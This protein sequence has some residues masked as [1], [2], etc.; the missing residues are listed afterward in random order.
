MQNLRLSL[1]QPPSLP[2]EVFRRI[3]VIPAH[4]ARAARDA[5]DLP[6]STAR[7]AREK[8]HTED[9]YSPQS[10]EIP[11]SRARCSGLL[12]TAPGGHT[13]YPPL[14]MLNASPLTRLSLVLASP[15]SV[16]ESRSAGT[17]QLGPPAPVCER[18]AGHRSRSATFRSHPECAPRGP[19]RMEYSPI[20]KSSQAQPLIR[21]PE[22][23]AKRASKDERF[24]N[25]QMHCR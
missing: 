4:Q 15:A 7:C 22:V 14:L 13:F 12:S 18:L 25:R 6:V 23:R 24:R 10:P 8:K 20:Y 2:R 16:T 5:G 9:F 19:R 11:A 3:I 1:S 17:A 21:H